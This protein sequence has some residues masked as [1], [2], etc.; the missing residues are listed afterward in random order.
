MYGKYCKRALA[1]RRKIY[2]LTLNNVEVCC[3]NVKQTLAVLV[4]KQRWG[5]QKTLR[6][7]W[8]LKLTFKCPRCGAVRGGCCVNDKRESNVTRAPRTPQTRRAHIE[9]A[10][11]QS[12]HDTRDTTRRQQVRH[13]S[14]RRRTSA[15]VH[16]P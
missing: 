7:R 9:S 8:D 11:I 1:R 4:L 12:T 3:F 6:K 10:H 14:K 15:L 16:S 5:F 2:N 13:E